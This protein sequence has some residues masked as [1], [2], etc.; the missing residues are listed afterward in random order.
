MS[1]KR[2][3][4][5]FDF[6][7]KSFD[8]LSKPKKLSTSISTMNLSNTLSSSNPQLLKKNSSPNMRLAKLS[9]MR[10]FNQN[11][12]SFTRNSS[13]NLSAGTVF[14]NRSQVTA[15]TALPSIKSSK[16]KEYE[17]P[18]TIL[19]SD[20]LFDNIS[21]KSYDNDIDTSNDLIDKSYLNY[22]RLI[23][24]N[25]DHLSYKVGSVSEFL[26][27]NIMDEKS[28]VGDLTIDYA[29]CWTEDYNEMV[30]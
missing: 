7:K 2:K 22:N 28:T 8:L 23:D 19:S 4:S 15:A 13:R 27:F 24:D 21:L 10:N 25:S 14:S 20:S 18:E 11:L 9:S 1:E 5:F 16:E 26:V 30:V 6:K 3:S 17:S 12:E 29:D